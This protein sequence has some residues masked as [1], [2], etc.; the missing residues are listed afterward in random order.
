M[1]VLLNI[2]VLPL[3]H[4][5]SSGSNH[6]DSSIEKILQKYMMK[7]LVVCSVYVFNIRLQTAHTQQRCASGAVHECKD[8]VMHSITALVCWADVQSKHCKC[9]SAAFVP[10][11]VHV[12][13]WMRVVCALCGFVALFLSVMHSLCWWAI[14]MLID[15]LCVW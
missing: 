12:F 7:D 8:S 14:H 2:T 11:K 3:S 15:L 6:S 10:I 1:K 9:M 5:C 13:M 4:T